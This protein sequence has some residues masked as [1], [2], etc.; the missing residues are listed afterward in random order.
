ML[1]LAMVG[2]GWLVLTPGERTSLALGDIIYVD[3]DATG[4][5]TGKSWAEAYHDLSFAIYESIPGDQIW[6]A[7][8]Y[9][10]PNRLLEPDDPRSATIILKNGVAI[11]GGFDPDTGVVDFADR[12]WV[13]NLVLISGDR[14]DNDQ[15]GFV[16]YSDNF[17]HIFYHPEGLNL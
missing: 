6:V 5:Q 7:E 4:E 8:G 15:P 12:D 3:P 10:K 9:Y 16:N 1:A 17:Y 2:L 14:V 13:A 11:Y